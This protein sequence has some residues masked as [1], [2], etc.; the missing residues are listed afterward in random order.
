MVLV[1]IAPVALSLLLSACWLICFCLCFMHSRID[2]IFYSSKTM[3]V[4]SAAIEP[5]ICS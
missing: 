4:E 5:C 1:V 2:Y 3:E